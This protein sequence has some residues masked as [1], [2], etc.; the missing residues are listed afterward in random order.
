MKTKDNPGLHHKLPNEKVTCH[1]WWNVITV[2]TM[3]MWSNVWWIVWIIHEMCW[4]QVQLCICCIWLV[5]RWAQY[6]GQCTWQKKH[7]FCRN[8]SQI[9]W[10]KTNQRKKK[11]YLTNRKNKQAFIN[12]LSH[13]LNIAGIQTSYAIGDADLL[14]VLTPVRCSMSRHTVLVGDDTDL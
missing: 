7:K 11:T 13:K 9:Y 3:G 2:V 4:V 5:W 8:R 14:I 10:I 1:W 12:L 6:Q